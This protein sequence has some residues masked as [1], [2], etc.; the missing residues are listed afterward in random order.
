MNK[1]EYVYK[2]DN[3]FSEKFN[4]KIF[5]EKVENNWMSSFKYLLFFC[6][7]EKSSQ[8]TVFWNLFLFDSN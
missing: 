7:I 2:D 1:W 8:R 5:L 4:K 3:F 6:F